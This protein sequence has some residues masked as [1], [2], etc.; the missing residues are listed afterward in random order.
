MKVEHNLGCLGILIMV[1]RDK[2]YGA[3]STVGIRVRRGIHRTI[4]Q[5]LAAIADHRHR[6]QLFELF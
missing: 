3:A 2:R 1:R 5:V 4:R 6:S